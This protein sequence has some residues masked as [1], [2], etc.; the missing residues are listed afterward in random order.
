[1]LPKLFSTSII[2]A[3]A[4]GNTDD[5]AAKKK[6]EEEEEEEKLVMGPP[7]RVCII[8]SGNWGS[9]IA[10]LVGEN[11]RAHPNLFEERVNMWVFEEEVY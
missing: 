2:P 5:A 11:T 3:A 7:R 4:D 9:A 6:K 1:M 10:V 8:G